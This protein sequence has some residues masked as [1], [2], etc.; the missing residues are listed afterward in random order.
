MEASVVKATVLSEVGDNN[1]KEREVR[2]LVAVGL[3]GVV[4]DKRARWRRRRAHGHGVWYC[5]RRQIA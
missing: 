3:L 5:G 4:L 1:M 2:K